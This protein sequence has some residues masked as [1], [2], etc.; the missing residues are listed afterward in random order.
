MNARRDFLK[1]S[2]VFVPVLFYYPAWLRRPDEK[3]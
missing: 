3:K 2:G 1:A